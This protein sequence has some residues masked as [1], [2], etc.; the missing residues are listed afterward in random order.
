MDFKESKKDIFNAGAA[1]DTFLH[2][3]KRQSE[4]TGKRGGRN[5]NQWRGPPT[6]PI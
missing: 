1:A 4:D 6:I 2:E 5:T 3:Q